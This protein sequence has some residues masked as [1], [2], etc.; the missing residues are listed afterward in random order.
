MSFTGS[1]DELLLQRIGIPGWKPCA[2]GAL[3]LRVTTLQRVGP[4]PP[5]WG[6]EHHDPVLEPPL[7]SEC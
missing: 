7:F 5:V 4:V 2:D 1:K 6:L 3:L